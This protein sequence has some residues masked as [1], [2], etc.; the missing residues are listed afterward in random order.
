MKL[1]PGSFN[2]FIINSISLARDNY[3][4]TIT[5]ISILFALVIYQ[6]NFPIFIGANEKKKIFQSFILLL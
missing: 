6:P 2:L 4:S 5:K 1:S 3:R